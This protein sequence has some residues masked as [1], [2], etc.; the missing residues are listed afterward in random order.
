MSNQKYL[1]LPGTLPPADVGFSTGWMDFLC[2]KGRWAR[3]PRAGRQTPFPGQDVFFLALG[4]LEGKEASH[5]ADSSGPPN[6]PG[7]AL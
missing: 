6:Q 7:A 2:G 5:W 4:E 1:F 3:A